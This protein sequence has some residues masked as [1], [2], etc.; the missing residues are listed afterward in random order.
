MERGRNIAVDD[1][2]PLDDSMPLEEWTPLD[3]D[4]MLKGSVLVSV[5]KRDGSP[6][7]GKKVT[8]RGCGFV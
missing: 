4:V 8:I 5:R 3:R 2:T 6:R 7:V 1:W